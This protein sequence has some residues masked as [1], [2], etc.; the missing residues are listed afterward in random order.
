MPTQRRS[1]ILL[2]P[3]SLPGPQPLGSLGQEAFDFVD[4]LV[5]AKQ[6]VWQ[7]LP[8]GPTGYGDCPYSSVS[9]FAGNPL[10][11]SL[12]QLVAMGDLRQND[13]TTAV[14]AIRVA[15][16]SSALKTIIP[17]LNLAADNFKAGDN[18]TRREAFTAFCSRQA[19]WL[20][21][22]ALFQAIRQEQAFTCWH[23]W[24]EPLRRR[25]ST[26]LS[27][28]HRK[29][30]DEIY[31]QK[32]QQFIFFEQ[33]FALKQY[34]NRRGVEIFGDLP[35]FVAEDSADVWAHQE[36]FQLDANGQP[37]LV[38]GVPPDYFSPTG[39]RW[40]NPLYNWDVLE[41]DQ[42]SWWISRFR[43]NFELFDLLR[44]DHFRGF[45]ACWAIPAAEPTAE[46][47]CWIESPGEKLFDALLEQLG[48]LP[49]VAEDLG[50]ITP[51]V[52]AL[53]DKYHFPG[54]KILQFAFD[55]GADNPYLPPN[56]CPNSVV[57][58]GTH[59][60]NTT[61]GWWNSL[62]D[63]ARRKVQDYLQ[64]PCD[65]MPWCMIETALASVANLAIIPLQDILS[66]PETCRMNTPGTAT[67]N[68]LWRFQTDSISEEIKV[69]LKE[70]SHLYSR[71]LCIPTE[72]T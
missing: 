4:F 50:I 55:S 40:G 48:S 6:S 71:D 3:T 8:L 23:H 70:L 30:Q 58:T 15:D 38:A 68:W 26:A 63:C 37:T 46:N 45:S 13:I 33:W 14:T 35:I 21:D 10:L 61:L 67:G 64:S 44:V 19:H 34:A 9:A 29:L 16:Y 2:H 65:N 52:V 41:A 47:G 1:G 22:F 72:I 51:D 12:Q 57:Y 28:Y 59:D 11:I 42:F 20:D 24:P 25:D 69:G 53:R 36:L 60:N 62:D 31:H 27:S 5:A 56:H 49:I 18:T 7:V 54:M 17:K 39:Q 32:Y 43:W 66:L